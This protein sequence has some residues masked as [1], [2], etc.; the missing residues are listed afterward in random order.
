MR[1]RSITAGLDDLADRA[2]AKLVEQRE[3]LQLA[4]GEIDSLQEA[5]Q[6]TERVARDATEALEKE[7]SRRQLAESALLERSPDVERLRMRSAS[8][9]DLFTQQKAGDIFNG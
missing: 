6:E 8:Q 9:P 2:S 1:Y 5:L 7:Q 4:R 3:Q